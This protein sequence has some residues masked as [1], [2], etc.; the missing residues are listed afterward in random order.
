MLVSPP[1]TMELAPLP[2][3][4]PRRTE[5]EP[6]KLEQVVIAPG[7]PPVPR[8]VPN[9]DAVTPAE[10]MA[11]LKGEGVVAVLQ[12]DSGCIGAVRGFARPGANAD[13]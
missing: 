12:C 2:N 11:F 4:V 3:G 9:P 6:R 5:E 10:R 8:A 13:R 1:V 7:R